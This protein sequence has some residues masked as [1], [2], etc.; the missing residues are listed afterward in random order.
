MSKIKVG[1]IGVGSMGQNHAR[2]YAGLEQ[3]QFTG[4]YDADHDRAGKI[5]AKYKCRAHASLD[6][7]LA[8]VDAVS[9][10][11]ATVAH[12][13]LGQ[14][15]LNAGKHILMEKPIT[16]TTDEA[17]QL[18]ALA[19]QKNLVLQVG[20]IERFNPILAALEERLTRPRFIESHR[21][22]PYP[23]RSTDVSVVL[24][25]MIHDIEI[26]MHIVRSPV[27]SI[28]AVGVP[29]LSSSEDIANVRIRFENG[30]VA[31]LTT[32][33]ISPE[34]LRK[35]RVFQDDAYLSLDYMKQEGEIYRRANGKITRDKIPVNKDEPLKRQLESFVNCVAMHASPIVSG[36]HAT[37]AL[38]LAAEI[39]GQIRAQ[40]L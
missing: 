8:E 36:D 29:V 27:A 17:V 25:V 20:H 35:I 22:S 4:V 15:F 2:I 19:R 34:K 21:L 31:N 30:C 7:M 26:I 13:E 37:A 10:A 3:A 9:I 6:E 39:T 38:R 24:D 12:F 32:S 40:K 28:D 5:A 1:V 33:R 16:N 14:R 11:A 18:V 23:E